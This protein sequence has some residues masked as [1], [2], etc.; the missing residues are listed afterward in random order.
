MSATKLSPYL[1][2]V[3][4]AEQV[5]IALEARRMRSLALA[6]LAADVLVA[7]GS[8]LK[9]LF[10]RIKGWNE[11]RMTFNELDGLDDRTLADIGLSR[12]EIAQVAA[13]HYVRQSDMFDMAPAPYKAAN[14]Q[15]AQARAA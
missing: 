7:V 10:A 14:T 8:G 9:K 15:A 5:E 2:G 6:A 1:S 4:S 12:G 3:V 11:R 13:G